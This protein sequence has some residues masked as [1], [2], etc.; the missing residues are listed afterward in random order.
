[1]TSEEAV[2]AVTRYVRET[3]VSAAEAV[4]TL[5]PEL[6]P[7]EDA[8]ILIQLASAA[9]ESVEHKRISV[10][11]ERRTSQEYKVSVKHQPHEPKVYQLTAQLLR[12]REKPR[13]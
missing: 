7:I 13:I 12:L 3:G 11:G 6:Q 8:D 10:Q 5:W 1:M 2:A 4:R 9:K